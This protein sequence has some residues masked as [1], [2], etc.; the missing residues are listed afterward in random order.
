MRGSMTLR[1]IILTVAG[2]GVADK[3]GIRAEGPR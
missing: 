2:F 1:Q 3:A